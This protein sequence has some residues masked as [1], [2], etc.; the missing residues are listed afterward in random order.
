[1][2][3]A[4]ARRHRLSDVPPAEFTRARDALAKELRAAGEVEEAKRVAGLHKPTAALWVVNQLGHIAPGPLGVLI[5]A[6]EKLKRAHRDGDPDAL[7][8]AMQGQREALHDLG[9]SAEKA[10]A[11][12]GARA[13][14]EFLRRVQTTVQAAAAADPEALREGTLESELEP[15]GFETLLGTEP[16]APRK[17]EKAEKH[18]VRSHAEERERQRAARELEEAERT[19]QGLAARAKE[20]ERAA[21]LAQAAAAEAR[22]AADEARRAAHEA[23][24]RALELRRRR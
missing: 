7:R 19:A 17:K 1:M 14:L 24:A 15:A 8:S 21:A 10:A 22:S 2:V 12:I 6:A 5:D 4:M 18:E 13:T 23:A 3:Q 11:E 16:G 9:R 20:L